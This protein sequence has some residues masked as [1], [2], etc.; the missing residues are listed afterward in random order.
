LAHLALEA[1]KGVLGGGVAR[2]AAQL[3]VLWADAEGGELVE[4]LVIIRRVR[5]RLG[6]VLQL[7]AEDVLLDA[8]A[9]EGGL[10]RAAIGADLLKLAGA[11]LLQVSARSGLR[12]LKPTSPEVTAGAGVF[13]LLLKALLF[14]NQGGQD[15]AITFRGRHARSFLKVKNQAKP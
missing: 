4:E 1:L 2:S 6:V 8:Y 9:V 13:K 7:R 12:L 11:L 3:F 5:L 14:L 15:G 10:R